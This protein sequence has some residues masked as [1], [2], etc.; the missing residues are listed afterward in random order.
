MSIEKGKPYRDG[1]KAWVCDCPEAYIHDLSVKQCPFD[2]E[3]PNPYGDIRLEPSFC[4][5]CGKRVHNQ[6]LRCI[7]CYKK[8]RITLSTSTYRK[9]CEICGQ[10]TKG[11]YTR[12]CLKCYKMRQKLE[13]L[14]SKLRNQPPPKK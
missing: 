11:Y 2:C 6:S 13:K 9:P 14:N 12:K 7:D 10:P 1:I 4:L 8:N 3:M 5:D